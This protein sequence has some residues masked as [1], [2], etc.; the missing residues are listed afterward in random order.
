[1][2]KYLLEK[3]FSTL[4]NTIQTVFLK[5]LTITIDFSGGH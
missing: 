1:M 3:Y 4:F 5:F 2:V